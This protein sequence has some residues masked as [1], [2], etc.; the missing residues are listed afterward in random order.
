M[1]GVYGMNRNQ[2]VTIVKNGS[3]PS[4]I[5]VTVIYPYLNLII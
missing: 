3:N 1:I 5:A 4:Y 2:K